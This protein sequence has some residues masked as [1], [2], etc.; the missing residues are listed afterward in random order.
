M[1]DTSQIKARH[2]TRNK[3]QRAITLAR[4][5][6]ITARPLEE[7]TKTKRCDQRKKKMYIY[8]KKTETKVDKKKKKRYTTNFASSRDQTPTTQPFLL[9]SLKSIVFFF[10]VSHIHKCAV[11]SF[12]AKCLTTRTAS[13]TTNCISRVT[14]AE[15]FDLVSLAPKQQKMR[16]APPRVYALF[17]VAHPA[18][19]NKSCKHRRWPTPYTVKQL[20][21]HSR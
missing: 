5:A 6:T 17:H 12:T 14:T 13:A 7:N 10:H 20:P 11:H 15:G 1:V 18:S 16:P 9:K 3:S 21:R 8:K 2:M 19:Q 4:P